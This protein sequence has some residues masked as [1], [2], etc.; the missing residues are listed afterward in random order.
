[1]TDFF[2]IAAFLLLVLGII[3]SIYPGLPGP[4]FSIIGVTIYWWSTDYTTPSLLFFTAIVA[5]GVL[6]T[7][8]DYLATYYGAEKGGASRKTIHLAVIASM[9]LFL[10][11][12]PLGIIIGTAGVVL[13]REITIGKNLEEAFNTTLTTTLA[14]LGSA[15]AKV[16]LTLLMLALFIISLF[17]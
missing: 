6:A 5:T 12:G 16:G 2:L 10:F 15:A 1:M 7:V 4:L 13:I 17:F 14:L 8:L 3:G 11:T 9:I